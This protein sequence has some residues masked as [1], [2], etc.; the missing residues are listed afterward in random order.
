MITPINPLPSC[1]FLLATL[2]SHVLLFP[3]VYIPLLEK[4]LKEP[5]SC[6][7]QRCVS[8]C[9]SRAA[10]VGEMREIWSSSVLSSYSR[11]LQKPPVQ[12]PSGVS[13]GRDEFASGHLRL[14]SCMSQTPSSAVISNIVFLFFTHL[15]F[16]VFVPLPPTLSLPFPDR[17]SKGIAT[18]T[19]LS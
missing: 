4:Y 7:R 6:L 14:K 19:L 11:T 5:K 9:W 8:C 15:S 18:T 13:A 3:F 12:P 17:Y 16:S 1:L 2:A 10:G